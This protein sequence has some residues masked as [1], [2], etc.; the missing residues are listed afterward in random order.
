MYFI[1]STAEIC[2]CYSI[3]KFIAFI[4]KFIDSLHGSYTICWPRFLPLSLPLSCALQNALATQ[5]LWDAHHRNFSYAPLSRLT[6]LTALHQLLLSNFVKLSTDSKN[7][8]DREGQ[9]SKQEKGKGTDKE[10][11]KSHQKHLIKAK[12]PEFHFISHTQH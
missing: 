8:S 5:S 2:V 10:G 11:S 7:A 3:L 6:T 12:L 4:F 1:T 9:R